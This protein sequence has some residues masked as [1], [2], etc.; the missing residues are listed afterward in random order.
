M[1]ISRDY[2]IRKIKFCLLPN[3]INCSL[4][5]IET[6]DAGPVHIGGVLALLLTKSLSHRQMEKQTFEESS[7]V[8]QISDE[9]MIRG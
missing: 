6:R 1:Y 8:Y 3:L 4:D 5:E 9:K 2:K 7:R